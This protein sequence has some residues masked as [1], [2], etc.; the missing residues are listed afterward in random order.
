[1]DECS[2]LRGSLF[3][4][5][6][7]FCDPHTCRCVADEADRFFYRS[8][9]R[10]QIHHVVRLSGTTE[11]RIVDHFVKLLTAAMGYRDKC[12]SNALLLILL[13]TCTSQGMRAPK[14]FC[15]MRKT[16]MSC[17]IKKGVAL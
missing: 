15:V 6:S 13:D 12:D 1:M 3:K 17:S 4:R 2:D 9:K 14:M 11:V 10:T 5:R 7:N 16:L 8:W